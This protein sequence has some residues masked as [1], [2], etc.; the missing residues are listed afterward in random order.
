[1]TPK[2]PKAPKGFDWTQLTPPTSATRIYFPEGE[3]FTIL[4]YAEH[5]AI[6]KSQANRKIFD[7]RRT[8]EI[9]QIGWRRAGNTDAAVYDRKKA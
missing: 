3:G 8:G 7:L 4:E 6:S 9:E 2:A 5:F 1:M